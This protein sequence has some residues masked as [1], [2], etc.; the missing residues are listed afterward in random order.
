[1]AEGKGSNAQ[2]QCYRQVVGRAQE[3]GL[4]VFIALTHLDR[5]ENERNPDSQ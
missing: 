5:L 1:M 4:E 3:Q 2:L